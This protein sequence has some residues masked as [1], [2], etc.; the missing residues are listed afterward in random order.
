MQI[1]HFAHDRKLI[2]ERAGLA[3]INR[4]EYEIVA[5]PWYAAPLVVPIKDLLSLTTKFSLCH[6][7]LSK[8]DLSS[9]KIAKLKAKSK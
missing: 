9:N 4:T 8:V 5:Y 3:M 7:K 2:S 6:L 1:I